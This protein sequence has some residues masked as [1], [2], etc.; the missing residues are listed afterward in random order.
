MFIW[1]QKVK[2]IE[3][4]DFSLKTQLAT[5]EKVILIKKIKK[6]AKNDLLCPI[7]LVHAW[8]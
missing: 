6:I 4:N 7:F 1:T 5:G 8:F 3:K 2:K